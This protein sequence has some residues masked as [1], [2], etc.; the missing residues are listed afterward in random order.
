V[1][2]FKLWKVKGHSMMPLL[3]HGSFIFTWQWASLKPGHRVVLNH[4]KYGLMVKTI[5]CIDAQGVLWCKG[6]STASVST[7]QIGPVE[8][9]DV[10]GIVLWTVRPKQHI[11]GTLLQ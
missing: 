4:E 9:D 1:L 10:L 3:P 6:E 7:E 11:N 8:G 5:K 2:G